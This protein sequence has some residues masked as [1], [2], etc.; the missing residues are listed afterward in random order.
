[1]YIPILVNMLVDENRDKAVSSRYVDL[2]AT[3]MQLYHDATSLLLDP[4]ITDFNFTL[5]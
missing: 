1:M 4:D 5:P 2:T 3:L